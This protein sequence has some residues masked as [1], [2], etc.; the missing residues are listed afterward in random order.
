MVRP[1]LSALGTIKYYDQVQSRDSGARDYLRLFLM[2]GVLHCGGGPGPSTVDWPAVL[3]DWVE[4][5]KAPDSIVARKLAADG[6]VS[7]S[8]PLC[9][10]PQR[11]Q[12][13]RHRQS[14]RCRKLRVQVGARTRR[15]SEDPTLPQSM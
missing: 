3:S 5:G 6:T 9:V 11:A 13:K 1:A 12:Y 8:R 10:Y 7:G 2:P 14:G 4:R 15:R